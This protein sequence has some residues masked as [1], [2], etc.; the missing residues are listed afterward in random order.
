[1]FVQLPYEPTCYVNTNSERIFLLRHTHTVHVSMCCW[2]LDGHTVDVA[3][4]LIVLIDF[5]TQYLHWLKCLHKIT[6]AT[7]TTKCNRQVIYDD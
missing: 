3:N 5:A 6:P 1:M 2:L 4:H 7:K